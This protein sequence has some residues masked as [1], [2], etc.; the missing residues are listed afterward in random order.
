MKG[1]ES[2][3]LLVDQVGFILNLEAIDAMHVR[4]VQSVKLYQVL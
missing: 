3:G 4:F 2:G 1:M